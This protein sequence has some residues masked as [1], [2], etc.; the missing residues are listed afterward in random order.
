MHFQQMQTGGADLNL[1]VIWK[2]P[3]SLMKSILVAA[4]QVQLKQPHA[5]S[6]GQ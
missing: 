6:R 3:A 1:Y 5:M 4:D 2:R